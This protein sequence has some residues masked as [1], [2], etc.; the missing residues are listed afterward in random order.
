MI[1]LVKPKKVI[2]TKFNFSNLNLQFNQVTFNRN[3]SF[4]TVEKY[5]F[6]LLIYGS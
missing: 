4:T 6:P 5:D 3:K 1:D 2:C